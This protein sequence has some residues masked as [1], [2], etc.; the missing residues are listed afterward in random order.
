MNPKTGNKI[1]TNIQEID[2]NGFLF[3]KITIITVAKMV[4][5]YRIPNTSK[6][7]TKNSDQL[8]VNIMSNAD[9]RRFVS[10]F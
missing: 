2:F 7:C 10:L 4:I 9:L 5:A 6:R 3:S 8:I 1:K